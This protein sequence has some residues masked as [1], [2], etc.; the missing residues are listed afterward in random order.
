[1][2]ECPNLGDSFNE[3][4]N[5]TGRTTFIEVTTFEDSVVFV[6]EAFFVSVNEIEFDDDFSLADF[7]GFKDFPVFTCTEGINPE[8]FSVLFDSIKF[9]CSSSPLLTDDT[10]SEFSAGSFRTF[11][12]VAAATTGT[13]FT[14][15]G[16]VDTCSVVADTFV[17]F[18]VFINEASIVFDREV[19]SIVF[20]NKTGL[21][22][23]LSL[24]DFSLSGF[25]DFSVLTFTNGACT[26]IS[27]F[28]LDDMG[29]ECS[30]LTWLTDFTSSEDSTGLFSIDL[31]ECFATVSTGTE[32]TVD[33]NSL[34]DSIVSFF[35]TGK[36]VA[37][38][39]DDLIF[40]PIG[41]DSEIFA[42]FTGND[43]FASTCSAYPPDFFTKSAVFA[44]TEGK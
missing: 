23:F 12:S 39:P 3:G 11:V 36:C 13:E 26:E 8:G 10:G 5:F 1:M 25:K 9:E 31:D 33:D 20:V 38:T 16:D 15:T 18:V 43:D 29:F 30:S 22:N 32:F 34:V 28:V 24:A 35:A 41:L 2:I 4:T 40:V 27:A 14:V 21:D 19:A 7:S 44:G 6:N 37:N 17:V 42:N